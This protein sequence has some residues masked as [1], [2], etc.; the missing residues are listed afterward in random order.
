MQKGSDLWKGQLSLC[1]A[2]QMWVGHRSVV[3]VPP[4]GDLEFWWDSEMYW[5]FIHD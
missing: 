3:I 2:S 5:C 1:A 4:E